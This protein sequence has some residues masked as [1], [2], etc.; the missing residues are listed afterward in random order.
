MLDVKTG[1]IVEVGWCNR[2]EVEVELAR[3]AIGAHDS[4]T[5]API[6]GRARIERGSLTSRRDEGARD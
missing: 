1:G 5:I 6:V 3:A 4:A 2:E